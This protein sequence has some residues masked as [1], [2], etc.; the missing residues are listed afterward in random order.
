M[1]DIPQ[2]V[3]QAVHSVVP[4]ADVIL[5]GSR[6]R[7]DAQPDSDWDFLVLTDEPFSWELKLRISDAVFPIRMETGEDIH[8]A[9]KSRLDWNTPLSKVTPLHRNVD[10]EGTAV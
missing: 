9:V 8:C 5:F 7:G 3:K 6:A 2:M 1:L 4:N 10:R